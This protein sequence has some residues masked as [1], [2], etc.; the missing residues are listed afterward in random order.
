[1]KQRFRKVHTA[2][3]NEPLFSSLS[4]EAKLAFFYII[5]HQNM[6]AIGAMRGTVS[7]IASELKVKVKSVN[8]LV[9]CH[10][11][12]ADEDHA[13]IYV[14]GFIKWQEPQ[15][16]NCVK[17]WADSRKWIPEGPLKRHALDD[18]EAYID[19]RTEPFKRAFYDAMKDD[20]EDGI[21]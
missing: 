6:T 10:F 1:M 18:A 16:V 21:G 9:D 19:T 8:E 7:G 13:T 14:R 11:I 4:N 20:K 5:T 2:M 17:A 3:W 15:S 12:Y